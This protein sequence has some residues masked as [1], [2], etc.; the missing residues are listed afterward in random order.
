MIDL[1]DERSLA[2][3][4]ERERRGRIAE[5]AMRRLRDSGRTDP[6]TMEAFEMLMVHGLAPAVVSEQLDMPI[7]SVYVAK[8][9]IAERLQKLVAEIESEFDEA[10]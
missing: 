6:R 8:S 2:D 1:D 7:Q 3:L 5:L 10:A 9:R 4:W